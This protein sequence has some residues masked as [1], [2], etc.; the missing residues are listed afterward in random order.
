MGMNCNINTSMLNRKM[1][2]QNSSTSHSLAQKM[3]TAQV[4]CLF[5]SRLA[6]EGVDGH[7]L[8]RQYF[9]AKEKEGCTE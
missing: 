1:A 2:V 8:Y 5:C 6:G 7:E 9:Y 4:T 3:T